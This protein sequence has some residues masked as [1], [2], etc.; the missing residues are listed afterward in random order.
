M[1]VSFRM[2]GDHQGGLT[3]MKGG[4]TNTVGGITYITSGPHSGFGRK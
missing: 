3:N 4:L 2:S 1:L